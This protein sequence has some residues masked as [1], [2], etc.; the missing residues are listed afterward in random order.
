MSTTIYDSPKEAPEPISI[1]IT[2]GLAWFFQHCRDEDKVESN[3]RSLPYIV[4]SKKEL[5]AIVEAI[6]EYLKEIE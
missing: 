5:P 6:Q 2:Y 3:N 1:D 4:V